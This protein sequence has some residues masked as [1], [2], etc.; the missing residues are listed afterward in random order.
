MLEKQR[1]EQ[2]ILKKHEDQA[3]KRRAHERMIEVE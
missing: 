3:A 1:I 2:E